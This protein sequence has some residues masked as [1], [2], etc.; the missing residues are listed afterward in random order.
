MNK[1]DYNAPRRLPALIGGFAAVGVVLAGGVVAN[2]AP[3]DAVNFTDQ[4]F[5]NCV[6]GALGV[7]GTDSITEGQMASI[8]GLLDCGFDD[9]NNI[10]GAQFLTGTVA[11]RFPGNN[12]TDITPVNGLTNLTELSVAQNKLTDI[13]PVAGLTNLEHLDVGI[14]EVADISAVKGLSKLYDLRAGSNKIV[15]LAPLKDLNLQYVNL[16]SN[17]ISDISYLEGSDNLVT[18][19]ISSNKVSDISVIANK[20]ALTS[21]RVGYNADLADITPVAGLT[22]LK[23][24]SFDSSKV[25][26]ITPVEGLTNLTELY[27]SYNDV[28]NIAPVGS[29]VNL[30]N[31]WFSNND[32]TSL[33][34]LANL[35][36]LDKLYVADNKISDLTPVK[37]LTSLTE[38]WFSGNSVTDISPLAGLVNMKDVNVGAQVVNLP[39]TPVNTPVQTGLRG[40]D[41]KPLAATV[42][43]FEG[44]DNVATDKASYNPATGEVTYT[45]AGDFRTVW[46][47]SFNLGS[48][49]AVFAGTINQS[50]GNVSPDVVTPG[51]VKAES[52]S[53]GQIDLSWSPVSDTGNNGD[54]AG[55]SVQYRE[56]GT[57]D[58]TTTNA[59]GTSIS[60]A[61]LEIGAKYEVQVATLTTTG[62]RSAYST[63]VEV[64]VASA[65]A[66][67]TG[68]VADVNGNL[69]NFGWDGVTDTNGNGTVAK[70]EVSVFNV[71]DENAELKTFTVDPADVS[72]LATLDPQTNYEGSIRY[73]TTTGFTSPYANPIQFTTGNS[74]P[75][76]LPQIT[77][78]AASANPNTAGE[79][80]LAWTL[81][82]DTANNG[83]VVSYNGYYRAQGESEW[84]DLGS[85]D[86]VAGFSGLTVTNLANGAYEFYITYTT[87]TGAVSADSNVAF[88]NVSNGVANGGNG[89]NNGGNNGNGGSNGGVVGGGN[90]NNGA[91]LDGNGK[92]NNAT[93]YENCDAAA[94][95]G[96]KNMKEGEQGYSKKLDRD[97]DGVACEDG[98]SDVSATG[99]DNNVL[100]G[101]GSM[102][103]LLAGAG[104]IAYGVRRKT[105]SE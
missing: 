82:T 61:G 59:T 74:V 6:A 16:D 75:G 70:Y 22:N 77:D 32:V 57:T 53:S 14:N 56:V 46:N 87:D 104:L 41:G 80:D 39:E 85:K 68:F 29:L 40:L 18:L 8:T 96:L 34:P 38:L 15:D 86:V 50:A 98:T 69:V 89:T 33:A 42:A 72:Y 55:Y 28:T 52:K 45:A 79:V 93:V 5:K 92:A 21:L 49:S 100:G 23:Q 17:N 91:T 3:G 30:K 2:A 102:A 64:T 44:N 81:V 65:S 11:L 71:D 94:A 13:T 58:W 1:N 37:D 48:D 73:V 88:A 99:V 67:V 7:A 60:V 105:V 97:G 12:I 10:E 103:L 27:F 62:F 9:I 24:L 54:V 66:T 83:N 35:T 76:V 51:N 20:D 36:A 19:D 90:T 31:L 63:P 101:V 43:V 26:D 25:S 47:Y 4:N 95:D 78:L 84:L